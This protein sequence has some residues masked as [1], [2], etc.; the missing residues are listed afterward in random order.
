M[1]DLPLGTVSFF[2]LF[3]ATKGDLFLNGRA[4]NL[5]ATDSLS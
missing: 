4:L 2:V 3:I 5:L 1:S